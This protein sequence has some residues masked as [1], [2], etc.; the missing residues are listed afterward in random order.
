MP[1]VLHAHKHPVPIVQ[2]KTQAKRTEGSRW[3]P[4]QG[5]P[6]LLRAAIPTVALG[7]ALLLSYPLYILTLY[8]L[9]QALGAGKCHLK[10]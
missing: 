4:Q 6:S 1:Y 3:R 10:A 5:A 7:L 9:R 8:T 2:M